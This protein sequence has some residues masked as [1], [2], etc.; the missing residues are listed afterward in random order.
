MSDCKQCAVLQRQN[1]FLANDRDGYVQLLT[2]ENNKLRAE[3][4][5]FRAEV[6][7]LRAALEEVMEWSKPHDRVH[8]VARAALE[9]K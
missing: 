8:I 5:K 4:E 2:D 3:V 7:K 9:E 1:D 6:E